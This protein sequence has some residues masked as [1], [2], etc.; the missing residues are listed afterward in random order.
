LRASRA[1]HFENPLVVWAK[2]H[3]D[4]IYASLIDNQVQILTGFKRDL[5]TVLLAAGHLAL[6][7]LACLKLERVIFTLQAVR[8]LRLLGKRC[9][10]ISARLQ[11]GRR[12]Q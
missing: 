2:K 4:Y 7:R 3:N 9:S 1:V 6:N 10:G 5:V 11:Q 12:V 8:G